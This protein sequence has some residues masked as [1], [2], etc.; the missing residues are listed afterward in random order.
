MNLRTEIQPSPDVTA[1]SFQEYIR[2][3]FIPTVEHNRELPGCENKPAILFCD[4]CSC[5]CSDDVLKELAEQGILVITDPPH[6]SDFAGPWP[7]PLRKV[8]CSEQLSVS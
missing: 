4:N 1:E 3:A 8:K 7:S 5:H 2:T 6:I